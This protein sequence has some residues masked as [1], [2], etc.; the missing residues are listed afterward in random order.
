M[1]M[2]KMGIMALSATMLIGC[3]NISV[4]ADDTKT[5]TTTVTYSQDSSFEWTVPSGSDGNAINLSKGAQSGD[6][7]VKNVN[8][9]DYEKLVITAKGSGTNGAFT[10]QTVSGSSEL[11]YTVKNGD[12]TIN[13]EDTIL[14]YEG[15]TDTTGTKSVTLTFAVADTSSAAGSYGGTVTYT[16]S[17]V[18]N[19]N[20]G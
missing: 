4:F 20:N 18:N 14:T 13:P 10:M 11:A 9:A 5:A 12:T 15:G 6:V 3:L 17:I 19:S 1:N 8:I 7:T 2:K 16:A